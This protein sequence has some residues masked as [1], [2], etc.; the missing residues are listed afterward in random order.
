MNYLWWQG[1]G[2]AAVHVGLG[3]VEKGRALRSAAFAWWLAQGE[4]VSS[5]R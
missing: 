2:L 4:E 1:S 3:Q 5:R